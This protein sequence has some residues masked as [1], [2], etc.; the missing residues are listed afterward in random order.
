MIRPVRILASLALLSLV[1][2]CG[3]ALAADDSKEKT[4]PKERGFIENVFLFPFETT[5]GAE[6][7]LAE[8]VF[9]LGEVKISNARVASRLS[10]EIATDVPHNITLIGEREMEES[11]VSSTS[12]LLSR[13]EGVTY[14]D[15][16]GQGL[17]ANVELRGFG[18]EG[19]QALVIFD[20]VRATEPFDNSTT[21]SM[22]PHE[23]LERIEIERG[24][25]STV[26]GEGALSGVVRMKTKSPTKE[27]HVSTED[28]WGSFDSE[29]YFGDVSGTVGNV[30]IYAGARYLATDGYRV[31]SGHEG[32]STLLKTEM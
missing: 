5:Q 25:G 30:G 2:F 32:Y 18:G 20:G 11:G 31:N 16:N 15:L 8:N 19:K 27:W 28:A 13:K 26:Y 9:G 1:L 17:G 23:Y 12:E 21:W 24:G 22:Y 6:R 7:L 14:T 3:A 4:P 10:D 29:R